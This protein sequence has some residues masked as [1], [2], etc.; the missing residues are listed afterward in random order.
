MADERKKGRPAPRV[1]RNGGT[2]ARG[3][4]GQPRGDA[5][6]SAGFATSVRPASFGLSFGHANTR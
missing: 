3:D 1:G 4:A 6:E 2:D 5:T